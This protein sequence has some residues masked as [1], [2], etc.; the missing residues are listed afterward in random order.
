M[1]HFMA[2]MRNFDIIGYH[3]PISPCPIDQPDEFFTPYQL[4]TY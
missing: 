3:P 1:S 2:M 4:D